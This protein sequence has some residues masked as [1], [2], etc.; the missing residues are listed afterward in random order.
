MVESACFLLRFRAVVFCVASFLCFL[1]V[2]AFLS[3]CVSAFL[4]FVAAFLR[5]VL[6]FL[7]RF[8]VP[9][10]LCFAFVCFAFSFLR[11]SLVRVCVSVLRFCGSRFS[12]FSFLRFDDAFL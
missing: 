12:F 9:A 1:C 5:F 6:R 3:F 2:Y 10:F 8:R 4:C 7:L 11:F